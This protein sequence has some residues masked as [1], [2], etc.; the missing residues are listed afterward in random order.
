MLRK[1][2]FLGKASIRFSLPVD[3]RLGLII[4]PVCDESKATGATS[5]AITHHNR[6]QAPSVT[7]L[8]AGRLYAL[9][10]RSDLVH[11][12]L[13][14]LYGRTVPSRVTS[15]GGPPGGIV[16]WAFQRSLD[17]GTSAI[18]WPAVAAGNSPSIA[19]HRIRPSRSMPWLSVAGPDSQL[20][21]Q[22]SPD[23]ILH[24]VEIYRDPEQGQQPTLGGQI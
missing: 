6:L 24:A 20:E 15:D 17:P 2:Q 4:A 10:L 18:L 1:C 3:S 8:H 19:E 12:C 23:S 22:S 11:A 5:L 21:Y 14:F 7:D 9:E 13:E 16:T